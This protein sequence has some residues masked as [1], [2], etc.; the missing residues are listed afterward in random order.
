MAQPIQPTPTL[1][2]IDAERL[3][4]DLYSVVVTPEER[5]RRTEAARRRRA[6][7]MLPKSV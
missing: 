6:E 2:G 1:S 4:E 7:M 3:V 5:T